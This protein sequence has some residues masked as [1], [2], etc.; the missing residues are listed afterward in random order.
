M[1]WIGYVVCIGE[2]RKHEGKRALW[3]ARHRLNSNVKK[4]LK[5]VGC[6]DVYWILA[7]DGLM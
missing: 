6:Q 3:R 2:M 7:Y 5:D 4:N 1:S